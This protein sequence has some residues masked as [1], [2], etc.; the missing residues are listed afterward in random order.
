MLPFQQKTGD[1]EACVKDTGVNTTIT[2][3]HGNIWMCPTCRAEDQ[4]MSTQNAKQV[5]SDSR[6]IDSVVELKADIF[7]SA[8]KSFTDLQAAIL[9]DDSIPAERKAIALLDLVAERI[10]ALDSVIFAQKAETVARENERYAFLKNAQD[11]ASKL[12][13]SDR[14]KY[15]QYDVNYIPPKTTKPVKATKPASKKTSFTKAE[16]REI[17]V[18]SAETGVAASLIRTISLRDGKTPREAAQFIIAGIGK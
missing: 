6:R 14:A 17:M 2:L 18:V 7:V 11:V 5:V 15:K 4:Q 12:R 16:S 9:A 8:T 10:K 1:C 13:E 3:M